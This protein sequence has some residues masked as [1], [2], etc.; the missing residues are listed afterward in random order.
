METWH[1]KNECTC[2]LEEGKLY[3]LCTLNDISESFIKDLGMHLEL[4]WKR[5]HPSKIN[6][7][8]LKISCKL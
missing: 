2:L 6:Y 3:Q 1:I 5:Y 7:I 8:A 4:V